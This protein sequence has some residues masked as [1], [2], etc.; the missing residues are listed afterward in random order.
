MYE[1]LTICYTV[2]Q[3]KVAMSHIGH[4]SRS[5]MQMQR[6]VNITLP[7]FIHEDNHRFTIR[8]TTIHFFFYLTQ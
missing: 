3:R 4:Y 1:C 7:Q 8:I 5:Q 2:L 6:F